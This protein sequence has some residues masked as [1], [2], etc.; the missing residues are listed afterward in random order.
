MVFN[1][2][3]AL[4]MGVQGDRETV[5]TSISA[6][7]LPKQIQSLLE[8]REQHKAA[9]QQIDQTLA[10]VTAALEGKE[11]HATLAKPIATLVAKA[12][13]VKGKKRRRSSF[14]VSTTDVILAFVRAKKNP[15]SKEITQ[16]LVG[17]GR[18]TNVVSNALSVLTAANKLKRTPLG[19]GILGSRYS[20]P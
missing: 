3:A 6:A 17:E 14:A 9:I 13:A 1:G 5:T 12:P 7:E 11:V 4:A 15:T 8:Q 2:Y 16:H 18:S 19:K 20:I 10:D